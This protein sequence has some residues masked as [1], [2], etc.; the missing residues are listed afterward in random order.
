MN[1]RK[2][3]SASSAIALFQ[4]RAAEDGFTSLFDGKTLS[5]WTIR[6]GP[7]S[8]FYVKDGAIVVHESSGYPAWLRSDRQYE[9]FDFRCE[10]FVQGWTDSGVYIHAPEHGPPIYCGMQIHI[11]QDRDAAPKPESMGA[12]FPVAAPL[13]VNVR[14]KGE[15]NS[16]RVLMDW[17]RLQVWTN[18]ELI[19]D[20]DI[21]AHPE[22]KARLRRGYVGFESLSYPVAFRNIRIRELPSKD[23]WQDL[24]VS[25]NDFSKWHVSE[26]KPQFEPLGDVLHA[27]GTGYLGTNQKFRDFELQT[28]IRHSKHHNSG[29]LFR[30]DGHGSNA[31][32]YEIQLHD[33][34]GAHYP[35]GSLYSFKRAKYPRI[36]PE[37]WFLLQMWAQGKYCL[38][39]IDG[40]NVLEYDAM[41]NTEEGFIEL[42]AH[43]A[44][45]WTEFK[46][47]RIK[48]L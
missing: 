4:A 43:Q 5:G 12:I 29:I 28:Y 6:D 46:G 47:L 44:G 14:N 11:F 17:P 33:V 20:L 1:R 37:K 13:K 30:T 16:M 18:G 36:E 10:F 22:L 21:G 35:T 48:P 15:W 45:R 42:Q 31:R 2:F 23:S 9:N 3:L 32:H 7:E 25:A 26:G 24:Y 34:E 8:A 27:D 39:R 38:V 40:E 19:Q 41:E